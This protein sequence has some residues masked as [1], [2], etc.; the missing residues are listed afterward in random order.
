MSAFAQLPNVTG[1]CTVQSGKLA[2]VIPQEYGVV[3]NGPISFNGALYSYGGPPKV[4]DSHPGHFASDFSTTLSPLTGDIARQANL[5]PL[6]S[7]SSG[8]LLTY[9]SSLKTFV[10]ST[11]SLGPIL[12]ERGDT[13]GRHK[14]FVGFSYQYFNFDKIDSVN[15][16]NISAIQTHRPDNIDDAVPG[17]PNPINCDPSV[18]PS[19]QHLG[20]CAFVRDLVSSQNSI[21]LKINQ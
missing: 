12:G 5:L 3:S 11:N 16:R 4:V 20:G 15:M 21:A 17:T 19:A 10:V 2:C 1:P 13:I 6:A 7:P 9:D 18:S 14:L 8:V